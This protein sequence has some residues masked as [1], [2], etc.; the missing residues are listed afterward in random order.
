MLSGDNT[1]LGADRLGEQ[2]FSDAQVGNAAQYGDKPVAGIDSLGEQAGVRAGDAEQY[3]DKPMP[4]ADQLGEQATID[5]GAGD[6]MQHG[7]GPMP[8]ALQLGE[9][10]IVFDVVSEKGPSPC[11]LMNVR[12]VELCIMARRQGNDATVEKVR[13]TQAQGGHPV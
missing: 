1:E 5:V 10:P 12:L 7:G 4:G 13:G 3:G 11:A 6:A 9:Q 2:Q 8:R